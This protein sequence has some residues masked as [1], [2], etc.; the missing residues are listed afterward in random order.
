[1]FWNEAVETLDRRELEKL[2]LQRLQATLERAYTVPFHKEQFDQAGVRPAALQSLATA[3]PAA[4]SDPLSTLADLVT[5]FVS[6]PSSLLSD[7]RP[8]PPPRAPLRGR[9]LA[10]RALARPPRLRT[11]RRQRCSTPRSRSVS[12]AL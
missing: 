3:A 12:R 2:Q 10:A 9:R 8:S 5:I 7:S 1:M 6:A 4:A 11:A